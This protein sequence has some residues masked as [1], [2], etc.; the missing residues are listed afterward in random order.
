M[1]LA[2]ERGERLEQQCRLANARV[3]ADE[4][5]RTG[6]Q[7][8]A[9]HAIEFADGAPQPSRLVALPAQADQLDKVALGAAQALGRRGRHDL[10]GHR[11][12]GPAIVAAAGPFARGGAALL[13]DES[14]GGDRHLRGCSP[15]ARRAVHGA[16]TSI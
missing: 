15:L 4:Q 5:R 6:D 14:F 16:S 8:A 7:A 12:P 3:A 9:A 10:L 2:A 11:V 1:P 13:A